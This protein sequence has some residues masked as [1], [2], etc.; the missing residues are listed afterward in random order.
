VKYPF[1]FLVG[2]FGLVLLDSSYWQKAFSA[3]VTAAAPGYILGGILYFGIPWALGTVMGCVGVGLAFTDSPYWPVQG[4]PLSVS[5]NN[6]GLILPYAGLATV[7]S[8]GAVAVVIVIFMAVT[9]TSSAQIVAV[10]S[11]VSSDIYHTYVNPKATEKQIINV[12]R[13]ACVGFALVGSGVSVGVFYAGLS[14]T[15]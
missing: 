3:D 4:R 7:G 15:W 14:L 5:E 2:N 1:S 9:S 13:M 10:S 6:N 11:I 12:S 8:A